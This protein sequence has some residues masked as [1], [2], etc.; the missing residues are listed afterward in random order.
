MNFIQSK[1]DCIFVA[2]MIQP[3]YCAGNFI[4]SSNYIEVINPFDGQLLSKVSAADDE[5]I[6]SCIQHAYLSFSLTKKLSSYKRYKILHQIANH[7]E[8]EKETIAKLISLESAKPYRYAIAE[9]NRAIQTL[10]IAAEESKRI[11]YEYFDLDTSAEEYSREAFVKRFPVGVVLAITPFNFPLNLVAHKVAPAIASGCPVV[12]KP[13]SA[14]PLTALKL[15][16]IIQ[17]TE[18]PKEAFSVIPCRGSDIEKF[19]HHPYISKISFTGSPAIGWNI[20]N[21][22]SRKKVTLELGGNAANI[23]SKN[24]KPDNIINHCITAG[25]AY[26]GQVCIH[27]QRFFIHPDILD[28]FVKLFV[29]KSAS[30]QF[31]NPIDTNTEISVVIDEDNAIRAEQWANEAIQQGA[32][33][34]LKGNRKKNYLEPIILTNTN[35]KMKVYSEEVFAPIVCLE[36]YDG[37]IEDA[38][39]KVNDSKYGLQC[40]VFTN[41]I[42]ELNYCFENIECGSV[43]HNAASILRLDAMPYGGIKDSG[44]GREGVKYAI[45][46][47]TEPKLLLKEK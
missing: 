16:E 17:K 45:L 42:K 43:I 29:E 33:I 10:T 2:I 26:S 4:T 6:E 31:G 21:I 47:M 24:V 41:D 27:S 5:I 40:G 23:I 32:K 18:W 39:N 12:L 44:F 36:K 38:V 11:P 46:E 14:T 34:L 25:F 20:K 28:D 13:A 9:V 15:A 35:N 22:A 7:I 19:L 30:L 37:T 1:I 3:L 8:Q